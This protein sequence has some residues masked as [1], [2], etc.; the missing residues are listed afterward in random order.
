MLSQQCEKKDIS[1]AMVSGGEKNVQSV[2]DVLNGWVDSLE[3]F[4][5]KFHNFKK[6]KEL[7]RAAREKEE[8]RKMNNKNGSI[9]S[10]GSVGAKPFGIGGSVDF[11]INKDILTHLSEDESDILENKEKKYISIAVRNITLS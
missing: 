1:F 10:S 4:D 11:E 3:K 2:A 7:Y 9:K 6:A 5:V 8:D